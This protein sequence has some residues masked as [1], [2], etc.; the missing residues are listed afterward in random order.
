[1]LCLGTIFYLLQNRD[2][3]EAIQ[4]MHMDARIIAPVTSLEEMR[5]RGTFDADYAI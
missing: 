3:F 5:R 4:G 1:M 2:I